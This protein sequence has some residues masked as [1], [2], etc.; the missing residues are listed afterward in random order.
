M[1]QHIYDLHTHTFRSD[2]VLSPMELIRQADRRSYAAIGIADHVA[3]GG[4]ERYIEELIA[5][6]ELATSE[7]DIIAVPAVELTHV[8]PGSIPGLAARAKSA[9]AKLIIVHGETHF[10]GVPAGTNRAAINCPDVDILAHPGLITEDDIARAAENQTYLELSGRREHCLFNGRIVRL[11]RDKGAKL[12]VNSDAHQPSEL[13]NLSTAH[14]IA[15]GAGLTEEE[16]Y[17]TLYDTPRRLLRG[18]GYAL[19]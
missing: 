18:L 15:I 10:E 19:K 3:S 4:L 11:A 14:A 12:L 1:I 6:C 16:A 5:D 9:G 13:F 17:Q 2:G 7:W 8:P